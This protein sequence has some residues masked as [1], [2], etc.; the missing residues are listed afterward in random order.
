MDGLTGLLN[1]R[2]FIQLAQCMLS[3]RERRPGAFCVAMVD[4][5]HFKAVNDKFGHGVGDSVLRACSAQLRQFFKRE[6]DVVARL[7]G[8][9]FS[10]LFAPESLI[11]A[12]QSL[13]RLLETLEKATV[14]TAGGPI[15]VTASVGAVFLPAEVRSPGLIQLLEKADQSLYAAKAAG[16]NRAFVVQHSEG[17]A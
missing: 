12:Q 9:E 5:D 11:E 10:A 15:S 16:R 13:D 8:E 1:R 2:R 6:A 3:L 14:A 4:V 17:S 7:G